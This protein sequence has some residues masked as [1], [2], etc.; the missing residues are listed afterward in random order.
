MFYPPTHPP[1]QFIEETV[2]TCPF[3]GARRDI[4]LEKN[5][6]PYDVPTDV[7]HW[8]LW[9]RADLSDAEMEEF[10]QAWAAEHHPHVVEWECDNNEG[11]R[12]ID[13]FHVHVFFRLG[14]EDRTGVPRDPAS[15]YDGPYQAKDESWE[16]EEEEVGAAENGEATADFAPA[17]GGGDGDGAGGDEPEASE[18]EGGGAE[19]V[20][21]KEEEEEE[22]AV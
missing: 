13:W 6:F 16:M 2:F 22:H 17:T 18:G 11:E 10:V 9:S 12:S 14:C 5:M 3:T 21:N 20:G 8:T 7:E 1:F 19:D 4:V 15:V